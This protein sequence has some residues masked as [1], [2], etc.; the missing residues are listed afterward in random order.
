MMRSKFLWWS[1]HPVGY[2]VSGE[3]GIGRIFVPL[4]IASTC[5]WGVLRFS[6]LSAYR[7]S[8]P[9]FFGLIL[10][11]FVIGSLWATIGIIFNTRVYVYWTG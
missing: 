4:V 3:W 1:L 8:I 10:G 2:A 11:D 5:K 7:K 9:L 6:G